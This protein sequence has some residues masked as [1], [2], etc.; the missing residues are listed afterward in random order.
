MIY[1]V[2]HIICTWVNHSIEQHVSCLC[3]ELSNVFSRD[4]GKQS[5]SS[6]WPPGPL[7]PSPYYLA[8]LHSSSA[9]GSL[10]SSRTDLPLVL[11][12]ECS[13]P[14]GL[15]AFALLAQWSLPHPL[16]V[17]AQMLPPQPGPLGTP[18]WDC[19]YACP[20]LL[21]LPRFSFSTV[22]IILWH[23]IDATVSFSISNLGV[24]GEVK[25][26]LFIP[27]WEHGVVGWW[28]WRMFGL[29]FTPLGRKLCF[30]AV[31]A[32]VVWMP[33]WNRCRMGQ[34][35]SWAGKWVSKWPEDQ[36]LQAL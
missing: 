7:A 16:P 24:E 25:Q 29:Y 4:A 20:A 15:W 12:L 32:T 18:I 30:P 6:Y 27:G 35:P 21:P 23:I 9:H 19:S 26:G 28:F 13:S 33:M 11:L 14:G 1:T 31:P 10:C 17:F 22:L 3:P 8:D 36:L 2:L 34:A 5:R